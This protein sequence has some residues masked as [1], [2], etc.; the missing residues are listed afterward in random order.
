[1]AQGARLPIDKGHAFVVNEI[2]VRTSEGW[3]IAVI[4]PVPTQ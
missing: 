2:A 4:I 3:R 1:M